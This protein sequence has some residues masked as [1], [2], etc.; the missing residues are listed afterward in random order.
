MREFLKR[1]AGSL[2]FAWQQRMMRA[3]YRRQIETEQFHLADYEMAALRKLLR[4]G[5]WVLDIGANVGHYAVACSRLVGPQ[6]RVVAFEPVP[7]TFALLCSNCMAID[8]RNIT[9]FNAAASDRTASRG[10]SIPMYAT[11][12]RRSTEAHFSGDEETH[13]VWVYSMAVDDLSWP[14]RV[15]LVKIDTEG[16]EMTVLRGMTRILSRDRPHL[17][18]EASTEAL[19]PFL[20]DFGYQL[21]PL[22]HGPNF[23]LTH[24]SAVELEVP[25]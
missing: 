8:D 1:V 6:G 10:M 22:S 3:W 19:L 9:L 14:S 11:G 18:V 7:D 21:D 25:A 23:V 20:A 16:H 4:P 17:I 5:D 24:Q 12:L 13:D 15:A 2:P